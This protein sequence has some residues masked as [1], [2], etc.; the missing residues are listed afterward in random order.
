MDDRIAVT[1]RGERPKTVREKLFAMTAR[2]AVECDLWFVA[3]R[4]E[5]RLSGGVRI[6]AGHDWQQR[7]AE[8]EQIRQASG[9]AEAADD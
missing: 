1:K 8:R 7:L 4:T 2:I 9:T 5:G 3:R 6:S